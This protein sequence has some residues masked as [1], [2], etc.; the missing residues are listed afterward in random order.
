MQYTRPRSPVLLLVAVWLMASSAWTGEA[1]GEEHD[2]KD[3]QSGALL[4][5]VVVNAPA[6]PT[7]TQPL[8]LLVLLHGMNGHARWLFGY[9]GLGTRESGMADRCV[10]LGLKSRGAGWADEDHEAISAAIRWAIATY[11]ID[12]RRI[13]GYGVSH[14][15]MRLHRY[16]PLHPEWFTACVLMSGDC[17]QTPPGLPDQRLGDELAQRFYLIHGDAD[18]LVPV[19]RDQA[20]VSRLRGAGHDVVY[21]EIAGDPHVLSKYPNQIVTPDAFAWLASQRNRFLPLDETEKAAVAEISAAVPAKPTEAAK[22]LAALDGLAGPA[23]DELLTSAATSTDTRCRAAA[24]RY[25]VRWHVGRPAATAVL[26]LTEDRDGDVAAVA[27][28]AAGRLACWQN[29]DAAERLIAIA[30]DR[31]RPAPLRLAATT[32]LARSWRL[33]LPCSNRHLPTRDALTA[34]A[35]AAGAGKISEVAKQG[36]EGLVGWAAGAVVKLPPW[37]PAPR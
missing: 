33:Q 15:A 20:T 18:T 28:E 9:T 8:A 21:R 27:I 3:P 13:Y 32:Q 26:A 37:R 31:K 16:A 29:D 25:V 7:K 17:E 1:V 19:G 36:L 6:K 22:R 23:V 12:R 24:A 11:P 14:G 5:R 2:V 34:L 35:A 10:W 30:Q 4:M